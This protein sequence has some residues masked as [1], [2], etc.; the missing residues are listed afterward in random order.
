MT[1]HVRHDE[2]NFQIAVVNFL[3]SRGYFVFSVPNGQR[4]NLLR[5]KLAVR[6]GLMSGV[7]DLIIVLPGKV[8]FVEIKNPNG[9][10]RQSP[11][12]RAFE[13]AVKGCGQEY[14]IWDNWKPVEQFVNAHRKDLGNFFAVG[15]TN[16]EE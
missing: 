16:A 3:R 12:Q 11:T 4:L 1:R 10:G 2:S 8:Y 7:S 13:E 5:A 15:G 6:E 14:L 9:K